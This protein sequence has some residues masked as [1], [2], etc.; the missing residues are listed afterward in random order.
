M[1]IGLF[2]LYALASAVCVY[3]LVTVHLVN[4]LVKKSD[5]L[6]ERNSENI[7][8]IL[9]QLPGFTKNANDVAL[10]LGF[11]IDKIG[12]VIGS[13]DRAVTGTIAAVNCGTSNI[14]DVLAIVRD[15]V[16]GAFKRGPSK[17][18]EA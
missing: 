2:V 1:D 5:A 15:L 13:V 6:L 17:K 9:A 11:G 10:G 16:F 3:L 4:K 18:K 14:L 7:N 8:S 12:S